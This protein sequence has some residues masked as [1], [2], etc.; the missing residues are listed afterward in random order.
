MTQFP[1]SCLI[2][3]SSTSSRAN[4]YNKDGN[5]IWA[6]AYAEEH[7][8]LYTDNKTWEYLTEKEYQELRPIVSMELLAMAIATFKKNVRI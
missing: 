5:H 4:S 7:V 6:E 2:L 3:S 8:G 1:L